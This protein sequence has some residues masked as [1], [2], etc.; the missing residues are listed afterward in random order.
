MQDLVE[1]F[2][3]SGPSLIKSVM[4]IEWKGETKSL[5]AMIESEYYLNHNEELSGLHWRHVTFNTDKSVKGVYHQ[6]EKITVY[7]TLFSGH[8]QSLLKAEQGVEV[9]NEGR[10]EL[11][12]RL[13]VLGLVALELWPIRCA[14]ETSGKDRGVP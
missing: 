5:S 11:R 6:S 10:M 7:R 1:S 4:A 13:H 3:P 8:P 14:S 9:E 2:I 12:E